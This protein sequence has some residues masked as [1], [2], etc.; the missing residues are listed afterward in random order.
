[1]DGSDVV[2]AFLAQGDVGVRTL[3]TVDEIGTSLN[4]ALVDEFLIR[5]VHAGD[6]EVEEELV[7]ETRIDKVSRSMFATAH[8]EVDIL[9]ICIC[10]GADER[11]AVAG[12]HIA[13]IVG[14][15]TGKTGHGA[16]FEGE[17][18]DVIYKGLVHHAAVDLVP[19]PAAGV[20]ER[21]LTGSGRLELLDLGE[22]E[23]EAFLRKHLRTSVF[24]IYGEGFA[25]ITLT[26]ENGIA[27]TVVHLYA[28][29]TL[30]RHE[31]FG[32]GNGILHAQTVKGESC[33]RFHTGS[34]RVLYNAFLG[35]E[36]V[37]AD[38]GTFDKGHYRK[39]EVAGKGIVAAV[40][41]RHR[42]DGAR[43][44]SGKHIFAHP[45]GNIGTG[46]GVDSIAT[47]EDSRHTV[48]Y[49]TF[50]FGASLHILHI[51]FYLCT[52]GIGGQPLH[53]LAFGSKHHESDTEDGVGTG[54]K[55]GERLVGTLYTELHLRSLGTSNPVA[56]GFL[57]GIA[58]V[59]MIQPVEEALAVGTD[60][61]TPLAHLLLLHRKSATDAQTLRHF[62]VGEHGA[63]CRTPVH[64]RLAEVGD[65]VVHQHIVTLLLVHLLPFSSSEGK[66][67]T[68]CGIQP[69]CSLFLEMRHKLGNG[70][71]LLT[72]VAEIT[73]VHLLEGPLCPLVVLGIT[74]ADFAVPVKAEPDF[75]QL[76]AIACNILV[77]RLLRMLAGLDGILLGRQTI[78]IVTHR[79]EDIEAFQ[80]L[81]ARIDVAGDVSK[82]MT[83][84][85]TGSRRIG[86]HVED[87][88]LGLV[89]LFG[90]LV[91]T[92]LCPRLLPAG[93]DVSEVVIHIVRYCFA[94]FSFSTT[95]RN[96]PAA[97]CIRLQ[98]YDKR[99]E[100]QR[101]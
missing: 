93:F 4:H 100:I 80:T 20:A 31:L 85:Q 60:A 66:F 25:P 97:A 92:F 29:D 36:T 15:G 86:E 39:S 19:S 40:V 18:M 61:Q 65:A 71:C 94:C 54:G 91:G 28:S 87:V 38:I 90:H 68:A 84:M 89:C 70:L 23:G 59:E 47:R 7:P 78:G 41:G 17:H 73:V 9:P 50:T 56:L 62:V 69:F 6:T 26:A 21:R 49:H 8:I 22:E 5:F 2:T 53:E 95:G 88:E 48:V 1:M 101:I 44:I 30:L 16:E 42:H 99:A 57:D 35:V 37:L 51:F 34:G 63:K 98:I 32:T 83:H 74:G 43:T 72:T 75:I 58:P 82:G 77:G 52:L 11:L 46:E 79:V 67:L 64:H 13:E 24:V 14:A 96:A 76:P 81:V 45:H 33:E 55:D 27:Q 12:V 3:D 10:L